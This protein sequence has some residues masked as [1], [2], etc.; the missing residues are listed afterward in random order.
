MSFL[1]KPSR[2]IFVN[3]LSGGAGAPWEDGQ[4]SDQHRDRDLRCFPPE[5]YVKVNSSVWMQGT[6]AQVKEAEDNAVI[7]NDG[8]G[9]VLL[10]ACDK[11]ASKIPFKKGM[12]LMVVGSVLRLGR[13][14]VVRPVKI[15]DLETQPRARDL[16]PLEVRDQ[17]NFLNKTT[18]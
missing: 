1:Q 2:K 6:V 9:S 17:V 13:E 10:P 4:S 18:H 16:W 12:Y 8:T 15:Q 7:L 5:D 3:F 14:P 11:V